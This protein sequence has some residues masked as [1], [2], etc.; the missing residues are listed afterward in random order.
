MFG[1][2]CYSQI[3][4]VLTVFSR[5][6]AANSEMVTAELLRYYCLPF[7]LYG[8][9]AVT[10]SAANI[11]SCILDNC[12]NRA[13]RRMF[14]VGIRESLLYVMDRLVHC[15]QKKN[16]CFLHNPGMR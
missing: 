14:G 3:F 8:S 15:V 10:L 2:L 4:R 16:F 11:H 9:E 12:I 7:L 1:I 13:M 5:S 6:N